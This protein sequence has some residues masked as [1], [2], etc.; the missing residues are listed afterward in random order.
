MEEHMKKFIKIIAALRAGT[1]LTEA[2][3]WKNR[4][5][6]ANICAVLLTAVFAFVPEGIKDSLP[7][8][9]SEI[10]GALA[11]LLFT[12][13]AYLT[14]ATSKKVGTKERSEDNE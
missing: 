4:Q 2:A 13:N 3:T 10:A 12:G 14:V 8:P 7:L 11:T 1:R 6:L 9:V 5:T